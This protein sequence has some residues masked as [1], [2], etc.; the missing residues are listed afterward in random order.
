M[1][2]Y[3]YP[4]CSLDSARQVEALPHVH[5][6]IQRTREGELLLGRGQTQDGL[7]VSRLPEHPPLGRQSVP[8]QGPELQGRTSTQ[9]QDL[10]H[11]GS[12]TT[13]TSTQSQDLTHT[14][15]RTTGA[16][17]QSQDLTPTGSRTTGASTQS[18]DLTHTG[19]RTTETST[20]S[21]DLTHT[22][23]RTTG[24]STQSQ[25]LTCVG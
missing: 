8:T 13:E 2:V 21:Q 12:R 14:G 7:Q 5:I 3:R 22:G 20:Q 4:V 16:S 25:D 19:S 6:S 10:T 23:S 9:S 24:A 1:C 17:T 18:Q 15:S 11:T